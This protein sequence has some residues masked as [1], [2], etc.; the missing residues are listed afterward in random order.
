MKSL[1]EKRSGQ[2][3]EAKKIVELEDELQ[4]TKN[5][6]NKRIREIEEKNKYKTGNIAPTSDKIAKSLPTSTNKSLTK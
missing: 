2:T 1:Y 3:P 4:K 6:Y 5:Y